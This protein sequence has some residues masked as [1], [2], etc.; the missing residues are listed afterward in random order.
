MPAIN[1]SRLRFQMEVLLSAFGSPSEFHRQLQKLFSL[2]AN[3]ALRFGESVPI[4]PLLPMYN[5]PQPVI[6][7]LQLGLIPNIGAHPSDAL[8]LADELWPDEYYEIKQT[9]IFILGAISSNNPEP[10]LDRV[11]EWLSPDLDMTLKVELLS[12]GLVGVQSAFPEVWESFIESL[13][14]Q[15]EPKMIALGVLGL[16]EGIKNPTY[17]NLPAIF[18]LISPMVQEPQ[19]T[20]MRALTSLVK[21]LAH[22]SPVETAFFLQQALSLSKSEETVRLVKGSLESFPENLRPG[23][24]ESLKK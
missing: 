23:L 20:M 5:L 21:A 14:S 17:T 10:I 11:E 24:K 1:P 4:K 19:Y 2:Y 16:T 3:R 15:D 18:R 6:R 22:R 7:Q 13:L 12:K 9:A 8:D